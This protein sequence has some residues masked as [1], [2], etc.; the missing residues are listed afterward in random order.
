MANPVLL[1]TTLYGDRQNSSSL[2]VDGRPDGEAVWEKPSILADQPRPALHLA[3]ADSLLLVSYG[4]VIDARRL[5]NGEPIWRR[6]VGGN[7]LFDLR[8]E[9]LVTL[10]PGGFYQLIAMNQKLTEPISLPF[11]SSKA[12][13]HYSRRLGDEMLYCYESIPTPTNSPG[14]EF[15]GPN[16]SLYRF[17]LK[18]DD[19][20]WQF[21]RPENVV[22]VIESPDG[23]Q[24][25]VATGQN[26]Y[27][28]P[29]EA[30]SDSAVSTISFTRLVSCSCD[31]AARILAVVEFPQEEGGL[32]LQAINAKH[33]VEWKL[34]LGET[35]PSLQP[36]SVGPG[37]A[38]YLIV[39]AKLLSVSAGAITWTAPI[40]GNAN[41][42]RLTVLK[43]GS[44]LCAAGR[45]LLHISSRGDIQMNKPLKEAA[46]CRPIMD[47]RGRVIVAG[48]NSVICIE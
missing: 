46:T 11:L 37:D 30:R 26:L 19:F 18:T 9:G 35:V 24:V 7:A 14:D 8:P 29:A 17:N 38:I 34:P 44:V 21:R 41:E 25:G 1:N 33:E 40:P 48:L 3:I 23:A 4:G 31:H 28:L 32:T 13:L 47:S 12:I 15:G 2:P 20:A 42:A 10:D 39:D 45:T 6:Q 36:P 22:T 16:F 27:L 43:D 5:D